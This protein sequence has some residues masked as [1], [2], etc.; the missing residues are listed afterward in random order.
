VA[1]IGANSLLGG[2]RRRQQLEPRP[3]GPAR[4]ADDSG[5]APVRPGP[6]GPEGGR[7]GG[8]TDD[9]EPGTVG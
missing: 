2:P 3:V 8:A 6:D 4:G 9:G 7:D 1:L 5:G